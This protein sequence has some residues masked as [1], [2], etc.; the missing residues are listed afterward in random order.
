MWSLST[1]LKSNLNSRMVV[2][3]CS[4]VAGKGTVSIDRFCGEGPG[5]PC[6]QQPRL[7][8]SKVDSLQT[9]M[10]SLDQSFSPTL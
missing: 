9:K 8:A 7:P 4:D 3:K 10:L 6:I 5:Y 1:N 2:K